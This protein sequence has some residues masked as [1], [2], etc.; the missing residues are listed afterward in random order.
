MQ[1]CSFL[2]NSCVYLGHRQDTE[3]T[4]P[5]TDMCHLRYKPGTQNSN[6][7]SRLP[8]A[9]NTLTVPVPG[10]TI[11]SLSIINDTPVNA[12]GITQLTARDPVLSKVVNF[13]KTDWPHD[14]G[15]ECAP[16]MRRKDEL[17]VEQGCLLW[18][19]RVVIP[20]PCRETLLD[21]C[22]DCHPDIVRMK[23]LACSFAWWPGLDAE[24]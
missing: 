19:C 9:K 23:T 6:G 5:T 16:Y 7:L 4:D 2:E 12:S 13:V 8:L 10:E 22:H 1:K 15:N 20:A 24:I 3:R 14:V 21:E 17:S 18:G 11:F